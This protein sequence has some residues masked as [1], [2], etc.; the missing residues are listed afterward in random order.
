MA[1]FAQLLPPGMQQFADA[2]GVPY[3][4]GKVYMYV[5]PATTTFKDTWLDRD[6]SVL[7][8]NPVVLD[9]AGRAV[10]FGQGQYRQVLKDQFGT[11]VWDKL[12][13]FVEPLVAADL[14]VPGVLV[15]FY[16]IGVFVEGK[17]TD[18]QNVLIYNVPRTL[19][20]PAGLTGSIFTC[21]VNPTSTAVFTLLRNGVSIGTLSFATNGVCTVTFASQVVWSAGDQFKITSQ[22][23]ADATLAGIA[24]TFVTQVG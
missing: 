3:D 14:D 17:T 9:S 2:N 13:E 5:P 20:M 18:A 10:I 12:V 15:S 21:L 1:N 23:T 6:E 8:Q 7:N 16:D 4:G 22:G 24:M 11:Q 19:V